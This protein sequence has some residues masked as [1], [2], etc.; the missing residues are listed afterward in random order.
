MSSE[1]LSEFM[2]G[3]SQEERLIAALMPGSVKIDDRDI[4]ELLRFIAE[5]SPQFN[6]YNFRDQPEGDWEGLLKSDVSILIALI[7]KLDIKEYSRGYD[8]A[9][10]R[11]RDAGQEEEAI[12][13]FRDLFDAVLEVVR[14]L[15]LFLERFQRLGSQQATAKDIAAMLENCF[16]EIDKLKSANLQAE[17]L[18]GDRLKVDFG[19]MGNIPG[20][21]PGTMEKNIFGESRDQ[22]IQ[23][24]NAIV[25]IDEVFAGLK[26][27][28]SHLQH[29]AVNYL[30]NHDLLK[31][32]YAPHVGLLIAFLHLYTHLQEQLN[33][34]TKKHLDL[35][36]KD[37]LGIGPKPVQPDE[38]HVLFEANVNTRV[39]ELK[40][41]EELMAQVKGAEGSLVYKLQDGLLVTRAK[42]TELKTIFISDNPVFSGDNEN[43]NVRDAQVYCGD[44]PVMEPAAFLNAR[45]QINSW[46]VLGQDQNELSLEERTMKDA[47]IGIIVGSPLLYL[48][49]G[50]RLIRLT[51]N[52]VKDTFGE[53]NDF[54]NNFAERAGKSRESVLI[55]LLSDAFVI[56]YTA[57]DRWQEVKD[58]RV[59]M[60]GDNSIEVNFRLNHADKGID[61]Y[62]AVIHG[63]RYEIVLPMVRLL[64][65]NYT[66]HNP[67]TFFRNLLLERVSIGVKV[68]DFRGIRI[69]NNI[70]SL[71]TLNPFQA[72]G[73]QPSVG[74]FLDIKNSNIFN[75]FTKDFAIRLEWLDLPK[76]DGGFTA[77]YAGYDMDI[78]NDSFRVGISALSGGRFMP[79]PEGQ[80]DF[81]LFETSRAG[82]GKEQLEDLTLIDGVDFKR[83]EF[84][85]DPSLTEE[86]NS[87]ELFFKDGAVRITLLSPPD[88]FG[89]RAF[90][91]IF[92]EIVLHNSKRFNTK[93]PLPNQPYIPVV[94]S[95]SVDYELEHTEVFK[96]NA[97]H[98]ETVTCIGLIHQYPFGF[99]QVYPENEQ[100]TYFFMPRFDQSNSLFIGMKDLKA[101]EE[102]SLLFQLEERNFH[103]TLHNPGQ[104]TWSCL[105]QNRWVA[106]APQ[107]VLNDTTHNFINTGLV[108]L[109]IPDTISRDNTILNPGLYW[110]RASTLFQAEVKSR[111]IA[112]Y[113]H[114]ATAVRVIAGD[115]GIMNGFNLPPNGIK[116]FV[117]KM[118]GIQSIWQLFPSF[119][120]RAAEE[121][122]QY[123]IR[124]SERLRHKQRPLTTQDIEQF[125]LDEFPGILMVKCFGAGAQDHLILP[126]V[127]IQVVLIPKEQEDGRFTSNQPRVN[128]ATLFEVKKFLSPFLS[129][130]IKLE[131]G[132]PVYEKVKVI[133]SVKF[134]DNK[135]F[136]DG[137]YVRKLEEDI[138][139]YIC[140][141]LYEPGSELKIGTKIYLG[142]MLNYIKERSYIAV[143][144]GFSVLHF[145]NIRDI[146]TG[147][148][149]AAIVDSAAGNITFIAGSVPEAVLIPSDNH[150]ITVLKS[151]EYVLPEV[152]GIGSLS[153]GDELTESS[154]QYR[155]ESPADK[156][157]K[158]TAEPGTYFKLIINHHID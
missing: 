152:L 106:L 105:Y 97:G 96:D 86:E 146:Q 127:N 81:P 45:S 27:K 147:K 36:F 112:I 116:D 125:I 6:Y 42:V 26:A 80:Q 151:P 10:I 44:Y 120:G 109:K 75:R 56:H 63:Q 39:I 38:V 137:F 113:A 95:I 50:E 104:V 101:G 24:N 22:N 17:Q 135:T 158:D 20:E 51:F 68:T 8:L 19:N 94:K 130:F 70:G 59:R 82:N 14:L 139:R 4:P 153:V 66:S 15:A 156:Q 12:F 58:F 123:H 99:D 65:N 43:I 23:I 48:P 61:K 3:M 110:I 33:Q 87:Q 91:K 28:F 37:I 31:E 83:L 131:V 100:N 144:T 133:A 60:P 7:A 98:N 118:P 114:A 155:G 108:R 52:F 49:G 117:R 11:I 30:E 67:F 149:N 119:G 157:S 79:E 54:I 150:L 73:P 74:A 103:H 115:K 148:F 140:S 25:F 71:S 154:R 55:E 136:D 46:P 122:E 13:Y 111:I 141:W 132:N 126:G 41:G 62:N 76:D 69:Q 143:V 40:A 2:D 138:R 34:F 85:N 77:Y 145:F 5:L 64:L 89:H 78:R 142:D 57:A 72:F 53:L 18:F 121:D 35:Y 134:S 16:I 1:L 128:L 29:T 93:L 129:P 124:V 84:L 32:S 88:A 107:E 92:P 21:P 102:L 90:P 47:E 9:R